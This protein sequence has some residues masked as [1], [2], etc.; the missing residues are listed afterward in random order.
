MIS[1]TIA[2]K[3]LQEEIAK[4]KLNF[5]IFLEQEGLRNCLRV[6]HMPILFPDDRNSG[7]ILGDEVCWNKKDGGSDVAH[8]G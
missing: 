1:G 4:R 6:G 5:K 3:L 2:Q 7:V 8:L